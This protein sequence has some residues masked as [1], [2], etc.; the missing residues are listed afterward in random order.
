MRKTIQTALAL[1]FALA[2][3]VGG[4]AV[5]SAQDGSIDNQLPAR[6]SAT[7]G[8]GVFNDQTVTSVGIFEASD[9]RVSGTWNE[10]TGLSVSNLTDAVGDVVTVWWHDITIVNGAGSW[11][12][13]SEGFG[14]AAD[15]DSD[16]AAEGEAIFLVGGGAFEGLTATLLAPAGQDR[17]PGSLEGGSFEGVIFPSG[18][19]PVAEG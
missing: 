2:T 6:F 1:T 9:P 8:E 14:R 19:N 17:G 7:L 15:W 4:S 5:V 12:G 16:I 10:T 3:A 13:R 11:V 18:W